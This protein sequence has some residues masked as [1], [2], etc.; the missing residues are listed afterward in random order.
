MILDGLQETLHLE[1]HSAGLISGYHVSS[2]HSV[3]AEWVNITDCSVDPS[4][5]NVMTCTCR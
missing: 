3:R 5:N 2:S 4:L 1:A